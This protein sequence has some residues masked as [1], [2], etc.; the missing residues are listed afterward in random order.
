[1]NLDEVIIYGFKLGNAHPEFKEFILSLSNTDIHNLRKILYEKK[2]DSYRDGYGRALYGLDRYGCVAIPDSIRS[3]RWTESGNE[4]YPYLKDLWVYTKLGHDV[5][6]FNP[7]KAIQ[8]KYWR[9]LVVTSHDEAKEMIISTAIEVG[10]QYLFSVGFV[11]DG[12]KFIRV[13]PKNIITD[14]GYLV[15]SFTIKTPVDI[16]VQRF[17]QMNIHNTDY[18]GVQLGSSKFV[19]RGIYAIKPEWNTLTQYTTGKLPKGTSIKFGITAPQN[20]FYK[21]FG[22]GIQIQV[23][24]KSIINQSSKTVNILK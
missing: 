7:I 14:D 20:P 13:N 3:K 24:S 15:R 21:H 5:S 11:K 10:I 17:G 2:L 16:P 18:W 19:G 9:A 8:W 1:M 6:S 12:F 23:Y 4:I 22:G